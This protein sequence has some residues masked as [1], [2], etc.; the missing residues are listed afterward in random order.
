MAN[1]DNLRDRL[2]ASKEDNLRS[3][4]YSRDEAE[5]M[6]P[7]LVDLGHSPTDRGERR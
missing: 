2:I 5:E 3:R 6:A 7:R 4:G 1:D